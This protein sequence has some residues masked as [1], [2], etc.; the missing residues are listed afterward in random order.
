LL[1]FQ[2]LYSNLS[3]AGEDTV[4]GIAAAHYTAS[5]PAIGNWQDASVDV[6]QDESSGELLR[7]TMQA[8]G[9]DAIFGTG[10]GKID[11]RYEVTDTKPA[12]IDPV[13]GC[14]L[15]VPLPKSAKLYVRLPGLASFESA[16]SVNQIAGFYQSELPKQNW[17][18]AAP[19]DLSNASTVLS[20]Q[21]DAEEVSIQIDPVKSGGCKVKLVFQQGN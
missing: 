15:N 3:Y 16:E 19:P 18:Q 4:A 20:Y 7:F 12:V 1:S 6:W 21:R 9:N 11:A 2:D 17:A 13:K 5:S 10:S 14:T 8:S